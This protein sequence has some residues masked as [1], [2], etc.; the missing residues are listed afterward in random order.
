[1]E[2]GKSLRTY[3]F[4]DELI[5]P[6]PVVDCCSQPS[7]LDTSKNCLK[8]VTCYLRGDIPTSSS[9][10]FHTEFFTP[11]NCHGPLAQ[12][13][14]NNHLLV[15]LIC[16]SATFKGYN[17][18]TLAASHLSECLSKVSDIASK[19]FTCLNCNTTVW[20]KIPIV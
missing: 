4:T 8:C 16:N 9:S 6:P 11:Q 15:C 14:L 10:I 13:F 12:H 17:A 1:M 19:P 3:P 20:F 18:R 2:C 7:F 5:Y